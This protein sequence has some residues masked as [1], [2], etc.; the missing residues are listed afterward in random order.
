MLV[1]GVGSSGAD[2]A[3]SYAA[4]VLVSLQYL[5]DAAV[6]HEERAADGTRSHAF[7]RH[8]DDPQSDV[9]G[10][11][12]TVDEHSTQLIQTTLTFQHTHTAVVTAAKS[13]GD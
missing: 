12:S 5:A 2:G 10:Q 8:L 6:R 7:R 1:D 3:R 11:R 9:V 4:R 13:V